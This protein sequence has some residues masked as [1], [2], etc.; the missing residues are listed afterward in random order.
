M[1]GDEEIPL[2]FDIGNAIVLLIVTLV[3]TY[4]SMI[5]SATDECFNRT[6][7]EIMEKFVSR[8]SSAYT[9]VELKRMGQ[10]KILCIVCTHAIGRPIVGGLISGT[11]MAIMHYVGM[12]GMRF[13]GEIKYD[14]GVVLASCITSLFVLTCGFWVFF[15]ILSLFPS[16]D[17]LRIFCACS[18]MLGI[19]GLHYIGLQASTFEF[20][21]DAPRPNLQTTVDRTQMLTTVIVVSLIIAFATLVYVLS[22]LRNWLL[23]TSIRL[24][25]ADKSL[26]NIHKLAAAQPGSYTHI[27]RETNRYRRKSVACAPKGGKV[28]P[29]EEQSSISSTGSMPRPRSLYNDQPNDDDDNNS[30]SG[31][32]VQEDATSVR[33]GGVPVSRSASRAALSPRALTESGSRQE[34]YCVE[35]WRESGDLESIGSGDNVKFKPQPPHNA[36][37]M[38]ESVYQNQR[39]IETRAGG[40]YT[41][42]EEEIAVTAVTTTA[43]TPDLY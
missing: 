9:M 35:R 3:M 23:R 33:N 7:E 36:Q 21:P 43:D 37:V 40:I 28:Y 6:Q 31:H 30:E 5:V 15:R 39:I 12:L 25:R 41:T 18:G 10:I 8:A 24:H 2:M 19:S 20:D 29:L 22:D 13:Q 42:V 34:L 27:L 32:S 26:A 17:I 14:P 16:L 38:S 4:V 11:A 1:N